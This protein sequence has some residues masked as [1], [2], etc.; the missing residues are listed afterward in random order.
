MNLKSSTLGLLF[1]NRK[2]SIR[3]DRRI[4]TLALGLSALMLAA[5]AVVV[6]MSIIEPS[7]PSVSPGTVTGTE[8]SSARWSA[9]AEYTGSSTSKRN[10]DV[11][12][13]RM[14][15]YNARQGMAGS[16]LTSSAQTGL[17]GV[18]AFGGQF[19]APSAA[20]GMS[21]DESYARS[22]TL[23]SQGWV[24][25]T[26]VGQPRSPNAALSIDPTE[27]YAYARSLQ[28]R[29]GYTAAG[30]PS[31]PIATLS[32][33]PTEAYAYARSLT[34]TSQGWV[35]N[36]VVGQPRSPNAALSIDPT[37]AYAYAR[38]LALT[39]QGLVE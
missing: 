24:G 20:Q 15:H 36:T 39:S 25:N 13:Y 4:P 38:S 30:Q 31:L 34:L 32:I 7:V 17:G 6:V 12:A 3:V 18:N 27:A 16:E 21:L 10:A 8:A 11:S 26:V 14:A 33:D 22:L 2:E 1:T 29:V 19:S 35:G 28:G 5:V 37:E 23:T 9:L